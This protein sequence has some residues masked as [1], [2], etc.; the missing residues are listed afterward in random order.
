MLPEQVVRD[1]VPVLDQVVEPR[2]DEPADQR[3]EDHLVGPVG[4]LAELAQPP[5]RDGPGGE[6]A[7]GEADPEGLQVERADVR[8]R[9]APGGR[10]ARG[11]RSPTIAGATGAAWPS[12]PVR[13]RLPPAAAEAS[14][15][16]DERV[17]LRDA[18]ERGGARRR[19]ARCCR[20]RFQSGVGPRSEPAVA[21][22]SVARG[23][24][25][26]RVLVGVARRTPTCRRS[27]RSCAGWA[28][29]PRRSA[30]SAYSPSA[31]PRR[32][33]SS[34]RWAATR[35]SPTSS[36]TAPCRV[37]ADPF[38]TLDPATGDQVH[39]VL[40]RR[41]RGRGTRRRRRRLAAHRRRDRHR[42]R[43]EPSRVRRRGTHRPH[44][45]H[46]DAKRRRERRGRPRHLRQ[47]AD[48]G[49][50]RQRHRRQGRGGQHAAGGGARLARRH[51]HGE[52]PDPRDRV[53]DPQPGPTS[54]T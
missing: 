1:L 26:A 29:R 4:R 45:R 2:A 34:R 46:A 53:L 27:P 19:A 32:R 13:R 42:P 24:G 14:D 18:A 5:A 21:V 54:S 51:L 47:R 37:T 38:D 6:E 20:C 36:A 25:P 52:R 15:A 50:R 39:L 40:R 23:G 17:A 7:E 48:R 33:G 8:S 41:A 31:P 9:A 30:R 28:P 10:L 16:V 35:G 49:G 12:L 22:A 11:L 44:L 43:R 3:G